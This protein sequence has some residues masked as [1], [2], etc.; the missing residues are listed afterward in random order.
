[1]L[2]PWVGILWRYFLICLIS[3]MGFVEFGSM[4]ISNLYMVVVYLWFRIFL[5]VSCWNFIVVLRNF[6]DPTV[7]MSISCYLCLLSMDVLFSFFSYFRMKLHI[8]ISDQLLLVCHTL[9]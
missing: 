8:E 2:V 9:I 7:L 5:A 3:G 6:A 1:M 4:M